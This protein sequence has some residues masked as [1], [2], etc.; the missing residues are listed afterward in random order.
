MQLVLN[1]LQYFI[2]VT[3]SDSE[4]CWLQILQVLE[5]AGRINKDTVDVVKKYIAATQVRPDGTF[6]TAQPP[7]GTDHMYVT[8][9]KQRM[10][11]P[12]VGTY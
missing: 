8:Q 5:E 9:V 7:A 2:H 1:I 3:G 12:F 4:W 11:N 10:L 6:F